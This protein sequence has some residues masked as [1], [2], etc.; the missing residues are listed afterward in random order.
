MNKLVTTKTI[1]ASRRDLEPYAVHARKS[2][3]RELGA[4]ITG[5]AMA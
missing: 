1:N 2:L 5:G 3:A 4:G